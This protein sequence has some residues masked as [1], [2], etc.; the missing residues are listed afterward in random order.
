MNVGTKSPVLIKFFQI[1]DVLNLIDSRLFTILPNAG[2]GEDRS[3][4]AEVLIAR[5]SCID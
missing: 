3:P 2:R 1:A 5:P 4:N